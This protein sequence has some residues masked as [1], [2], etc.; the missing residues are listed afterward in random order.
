MIS[1]TAVWTR[2]HRGALMA[3]CQ[4]RDGR[5]AAFRRRS[6]AEDGGSSDLVV[7]RGMTA[8]SVREEDREQAIAGQGRGSAATRIVARDARQSEARLRTRGLPSRPSKE[9]ARLRGE[10]LAMATSPHRRKL[11]D[12]SALRPHPKRARRRRPSALA[13]TRERHT[14]AAVATPLSGEAAS[15]AIGAGGRLRASR[16]NHGVRALNRPRRSSDGSCE[17]SSP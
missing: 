14:D 8:T 11:C 7:A 9:S 17:R 2:D 3:I 10:S 4:R 16:G 6:A 12:A 1:L 5:P 13:A 15:P